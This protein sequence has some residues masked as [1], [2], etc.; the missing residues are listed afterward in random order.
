MAA[1]KLELSFCF[2]ACTPRR[3]G[4]V[5]VQE[6]SNVIERLR[7]EVIT[8]IDQFSYEDERDKYYE[9]ITLPKQ[10]PRAQ[11]RMKYRDT[12]ENNSPQLRFQKV[13]IRYA[14]MY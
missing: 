10:K 5:G 12:T 4:A 7:P 11:L 13:S 8:S 14:Y 2:L 1:D 3:P 9:Q 6:I